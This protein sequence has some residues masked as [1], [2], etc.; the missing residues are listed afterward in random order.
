V[1][2]VGRRSHLLRGP[3]GH[4]RAALLAALGPRSM[5]RSAVLMTSRLC[6]MMTLDF[7]GW[8]W[9]AGL[10]VMVLASL[11]DREGFYGTGHS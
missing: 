3:V 10:V 9:M 4:H 2:A 6:S 8:A 11:V 1:R 7:S 5:M